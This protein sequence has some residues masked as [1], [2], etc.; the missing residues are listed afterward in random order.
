MFRNIFIYNSHP[1]YDNVCQIVTQVEIPH[2]NV[3]LLSR[4]KFENKVQFDFPPS[5]SH[6]TKFDFRH[7]S[8][9]GS[10]INGILCIFY[11]KNN[12]SLWNPATEK[13]KI[14]HLSFA[15]FKPGLITCITHHGYGYDH[16]TRDYKVIQDVGYFIRIN[17]YPMLNSF[18]EIYSLKSNSKRKNDFDRPNI[19]ISWIDNNSMYIT[20][21]CHWWRLSNKF[22]SFNLCNEEFFITP[23]FLEDLP[24]DFEE[25]I[26]VNH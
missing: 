22:V 24:N 4:D 8:V 6:I 10:V 14:I 15:K 11:K 25:C 9:L 12:A 23:T 2:W 17:K 26:I 18:W 20:G 7:F 3:D 1:H 16:V 21:V 19:A 5:P 13:I